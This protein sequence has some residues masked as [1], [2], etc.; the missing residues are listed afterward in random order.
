MEMEKQMF[1]KQKFAGPERDNGTQGG[2]L[3]DFAR[4]LPVYTPS[5]YCNYLWQQLP[6]WNE[7]SVYILLGRQRECQSFFLTFLGLDC[8]QLKIIHRSKRH[9][10]GAS[11]VPLHYPLLFINHPQTQS[12]KQGM[13]MISVSKEQE[14]RSGLSGQFWLLVKL[15]LHQDL[16]IA[17]DLLLS[18]L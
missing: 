7:S 11:F 17:E 6:S 10:G 18:Q 4:F 3:M 16:T 15:Q 8:F 9:F 2:I 1:G 14:G 13:F 12:L 5:S